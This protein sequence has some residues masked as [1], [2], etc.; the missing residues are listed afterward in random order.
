M[1]IFL[2]NIIKKLLLIFGVGLYKS[3]NKK[4]LLDIIKKFRPY[5]LGYNLIR[6][7]SKH[8]GGYLVPNIL[9]KIDF[10]I[11]PGVDKTVSFEK[12]LLKDY[13]IKSFLLDH[14]V[15]ENEKFLKDFDFTNEDGTRNTKIVAEYID[16]VTDFLSKNPKLKTG[17]DLGCGDFSVGVHFCELF[18][19]YS[20]ADVAE[21]VIK[22]NRKIYRNK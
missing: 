6:I 2:Q 18:K 16:V 7:G 14:T 20:A 21:N 17:L 19:N 13:D 5:E 8:D 12:Q 10:C 22:E 15:D 4:H 1:R 9:D 3:Q 11:S